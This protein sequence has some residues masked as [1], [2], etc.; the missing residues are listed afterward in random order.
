LHSS[1][2]TNLDIFEAC[3]SGKG[4]VLSHWSTNSCAFFS[5]A[6]LAFCFATRDPLKTNSIIFTVT[7]QR[8]IHSSFDVVICLPLHV[9]DRVKNILKHVLF[10]VHDVK[11]MAEEIDL[12]IR[13]LLKNTSIYLVVGQTKTKKLL[14]TGLKTKHNV[15]IL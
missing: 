3:P 2:L 9:H 12:S 10:Y 5:K 1:K 4:K 7:K 15:I 6:K 11:V 13:K 8:Y 14:L